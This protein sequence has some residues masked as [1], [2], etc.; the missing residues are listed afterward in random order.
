MKNIVFV[1]TGNTCR[2]PMAEGYLKNKKTA[3]YSISS[4]GLCADGSPASENSVAVMKE[5]GLDISSHISRQMI[6][7]DAEKADVIVCM[8][9][10]HADLLESL[11]IDKLKVH[12]LGISD[13]YGQEISVYRTCR[14][15]ITEAIDELIGDGIL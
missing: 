6:Y 2:R 10:S 8:S 5:I 4:R 1:C 7:S 11:G 14:D 9:S 15:E 13:P 12:I 3:G